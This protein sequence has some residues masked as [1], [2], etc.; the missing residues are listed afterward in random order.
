[1]LWGNLK[2]CVVSSCQAAEAAWASTHRVLVLK[3]PGGFQSSSIQLMLAFQSAAAWCQSHQR[4]APDDKLNRDPSWDHRE[5]LPCWLHYTGRKTIK[6]GV[7]LCKKKK[8]SSSES[9]QWHSWEALE[10]FY[11]LHRCRNGILQRDSNK[12]KS[13]HKVAFAPSPVDLLKWNVWERRWVRTSRTSLATASI[14]QNQREQFLLILLTRSPISHGLLASRED[15]ELCFISDCF[16]YS[17]YS[18]EKTGMWF[19]KQ[20]PNFIVHWIPH[21]QVSVV[22]FGKSLFSVSCSFKE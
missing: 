4:A 6:M 8:L 12:K 15:Y 18:L 9:H 14:S 17:N 2:H 3:P 10:D 19:I 11:K 1:M 21:P 22:S 13:L 20:R 5:E 7:C 16:V